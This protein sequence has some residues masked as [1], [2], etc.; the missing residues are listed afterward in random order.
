MSMSIRGE[1]EEVEDT[2]G[3]IAEEGIITNTGTLLEVTQSHVYMV[4]QSVKDYFDKRRPLDGRFDNGKDSELHLAKICMNYLDLEDFEKTSEVY[5][6]E[7]QKRNWLSSC[8]SGGRL[9]PRKNEHILLDY[10]SSS[11]Y[12]HIRTDKEAME[13]RPF[14]ERFFSQYR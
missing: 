1:N 14:I 7:L 2:P 12:R 3:T 6:E 5:D 10:A 8:L 11:W 13:F 9:Y 4:H